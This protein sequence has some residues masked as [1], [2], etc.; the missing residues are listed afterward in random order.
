[1]KR[2]DKETGLGNVE[3]DAYTC[4][5]P[6][7][8]YTHKK[9]VANI[10]GV[11]APW[12][13]EMRELFR[14]PMGFYQVGVDLSGIEARVLCHLCY[15][16]EGG[17]EFAELV[18]EGDW[19]SVNAK[20]W[21]VSRK[22]AKGILYAMMY[23]AGDGNLGAQAGSG[24]SNRG[25]KIRK[26]FLE[27]NPAYAK[28]VED[29]TDAWQSNKFIPSMDGRPL[30]PRSKK[31]VLNTTIQGNSAVIFKKWMIR[32]DKLVDV[33]EGYAHQMIAYHDELQF[34][35]YGSSGDYRAESFGEKVVQEALLT[36]LDMGI[37]VPIG[38]EAK[39]GKTYADCH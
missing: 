4:G 16:Y 39:I 32:C 6:T 14:G 27:S 29:L 11:E 35:Y 25:A 8:R 38:A 36:G 20:N 33:R 19:H 37:K 30:Y 13:I 26:V 12:G 18:L 1:M 17:P 34:A 9:P 23:G 15:D 22:V 24:G 21:G 5:T 28:L 10:P 7:A 31:D 2:Y 3:S